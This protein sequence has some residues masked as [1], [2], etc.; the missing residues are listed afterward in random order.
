[1]RKMLNLGCGSRFH[2][3]F[4]NIDLYAPTKEIMACDAKRPLEFNDNTFDVVYHSHLLEH[5]NR[6]DGL[7]LLRECYRVCKPGGV[8]RVVVPDLENIAL[9]YLKY[10]EH[11]SL[12]ERGMGYCYDWMLLE[13]FDQFVRTRSGGD[14]S[15]F[16]CSAP[17]EIWSFLESR[18]GLSLNS[19]ENI[20]E[21]R[22]TRLFRLC[23]SKSNLGKKLKY[24]IKRNIS[25]TLLILLWGNRGGEIS[26]EVI[27]RLQGENHK[28]MYD[29]FSLVRALEGAGFFKI[30]VCSENESRIEGWN[31]Y[32]LDTEPDGSSYKPNSLYCEAEK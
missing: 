23:T 8:I 20:K 17:D 9:L 1:M 7:R 29:R 19:I 3:D 6:Q 14:M 30:A 22:F 27:F 24:H 31:R 15:D 32:C 13:L 4:I 5:F 11:V 12:G 21:S 18:T 2:P 26:D 10:L 28:W 16:I 25:R